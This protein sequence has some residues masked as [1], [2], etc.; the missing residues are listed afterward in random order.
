MCAALECGMMM[1]EDMLCD[2]SSH[3]CCMSSNVG[4]VGLVARVSLVHGFPRE[5]ELMHARVTPHYTRTYMISFI[6]D[7]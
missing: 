6:R 5:C 4:E 3:M 1:A 2:N 7:A